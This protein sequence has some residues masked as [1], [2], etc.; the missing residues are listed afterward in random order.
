MII[1]KLV[2]IVMNYSAPKRSIGAVQGEGK[3]GR[4]LRKCECGRQTL[5]GKKN[6]E[7]QRE[8]K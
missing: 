3:Y 1:I 6:E 2:F 7:R 4:L 8:E 5:A